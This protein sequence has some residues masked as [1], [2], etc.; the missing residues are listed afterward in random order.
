MAQ[1]QTTDPINSLLAE[2]GTRLNEVEEKQ[3]LLRDRAL[4]IGEN[5]ISTKEENNNENQELRNKVNTLETE[6][7]DLKKLM[8]RVINELENFVRKE[9]FEILKK[10]FDMFQPLKLA[11]VKDVED[12]I[13]QHLN[14]KTS[15]PSK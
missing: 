8:K 1:E 3:R 14:L 7:K 9:E 10:Q 4:L 15:N 2:F 6:I 5:L 11:R 13:S 12:M